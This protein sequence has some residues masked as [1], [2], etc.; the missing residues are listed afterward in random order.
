M[1]KPDRKMEIIENQERNKEIMN[2]KWINKEKKNQDIDN[3]EET[4][5]VKRDHKNQKAW[6]P[7]NKIGAISEYMKIRSQMMNRDYIFSYFKPA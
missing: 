4:E 2:I 3:K 1:N 5:K 7:V 6:T